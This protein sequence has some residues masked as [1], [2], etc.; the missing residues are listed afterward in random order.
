MWDSDSG[1]N[2]LIQM[3]NDIRVGGLVSDEERAVQEAQEAPAQRVAVVPGKEG[4]IPDSP[5][6]VVAGEQVE[7]VRA[8]DADL[9]PGGLSGPGSYE[10]A[11][12]MF[13]P[14]V[15][16]GPDVAKRVE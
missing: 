1:S 16:P 3:A 15:M 4:E 7:P 6:V 9:K 13:A 12:R 10:A 8:E 11:M 14:P 2:P 5:E